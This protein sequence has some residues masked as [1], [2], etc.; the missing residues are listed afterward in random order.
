MLISKILIGISAAILL[1][2]STIMTGAVY[3]QGAVTINGAGATFP[4]PL[5][6]TWRVEYQKVKPDVNINY[7]SI[8]S[9]GGVK[10]F[11]E[12]TVDFGA[13]DAPLTQNESQKAPGAV[14]IP[15]TIGSVVAAYNIPSIPGKG[16][17][18]TGEV[19]ADIFLGKITKWND[20]KIQSL[21]TD[22]TLPGDDI[23]VVHRSDGSGTTFVWTD[24]LS[25]ASPA[26][27][28]QLGK[29]KSVEWPAG[30]GAPGNEGVANAIKGTPNTI[31]YIEL[32]YALTTNTPFAFIQNKEGNFVEPSLNSTMSAVESYVATL[33]KGDGVW[34]D[35]TLV[36]AAGADSYPIASFSYLLLN[37]ELSTN[38][39]LDQAKAKALVDFISWAITNG[40]KMAE[41]LDYVPLPDGV[42]KLDQDTLK[43]L[44]FNGQP[45][46]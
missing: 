15:E 31:G 35:V 42:V 2:T 21:N 5:I 37:K 32:S 39:N 7:Q 30:I 18:L 10:Q 44:T 28:D 14:H 27:K 23:V 11:T 17:K 3:A 8:G 41:S 19:L 1:A 20:P 24:Y 4:F 26:W 36:N 16:L 38:P 43:S 13:T 40:Q 6:D 46:T 29:G 33:P 45:I 34:T 9:G 22:K 12:N 25:T